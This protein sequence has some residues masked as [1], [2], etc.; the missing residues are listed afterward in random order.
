MIRPPHTTFTQKVLQGKSESP[1]PGISGLHVLSD[2]Q[3]TDIVG[4]GLMAVFLFFR[5]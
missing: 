4:T 2:Q 1:L 3:S 5:Q